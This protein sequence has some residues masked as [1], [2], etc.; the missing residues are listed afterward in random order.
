MTTPGSLFQPATR[1]QLKARIAF[2]GPTGS[3][4]TWTALAWAQ[5]LAGPDGR[6][7]VIDTE[8]RSAS[9]YIGVYQFEVLEWTPPYDPRKL[10]EAI[11]AAGTEGFDVIVV[12]SLTHFWKKQGGTI[13]IAEAAG[14]Q[15]GGNS[16]A[17]W[18]TA[19]PAI[20]SVVDAMLQSPAH[21]IATMRS[22]MEHLLVEN[23]RG[24]Q[25]PTK[26]GMAPEM[27][28]DIEY[29]FT[30]AISMDLTHAGLVT[31]SR[32]SALADR[33]IPA[34]STAADDAAEEFATW[35]E[36]GDVGTE[37]AATEQVAELMTTVQGLTNEAQRDIKANWPAGFPSLKNT[38]GWTAAQFAT[39]S[40]LVAGFID[41]PANDSDH[42]PTHVNTDEVAR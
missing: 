20:E 37:M 34:G 28:G 3:G 12:D 38:T 27:R 15:N 39:V 25:V 2:D 24:K 14:R 23:A 26:V 11:R 17:G 16:F 41:T 18:K 4:K 36:M 29:E 5:H 13:D 35:L 7:A 30:L 10:A 6:I 21:V 1:H 31:K 40:A 9:L 22:K 32:C 42:K 19:T 33:V 8:N